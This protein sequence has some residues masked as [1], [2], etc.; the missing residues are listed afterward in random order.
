MRPVFGMT[1]GLALL[2]AGTAGAQSFSPPPSGSNN[3][4]TSPGLPQPYGLRWQSLGGG[5]SSLGLD[6]TARS[7]DLQFPQSTGVPSTIYGNRTSPI[8]RYTSRS[9]PLSPLQ[10][11]FGLPRSIQPPAASS[12]PLFG[13]NRLAEPYQPG[14]TPSSA[15]GLQAGR[16]RP[17]GPLPVYPVQPVAPLAPRDQGPTAYGGPHA[18]AA[19]GGAGML[20]LPRL[21]W[22][23]PEE[24]VPPPQTGGPGASNLIQQRPFETGTLPGPMRLGSPLDQIVQ[25]Q[26]YGAMGGTRLA[27]PEGSLR[28]PAPTPERPAAPTG[29]PPATPGQPS[30]AIRAGQQPL[31][32]PAGVE[33][34]TTRKYLDKATAELKAGDYPKAAGSYELARVVAPRS[35]APLLGRTVAL[36]ATGDLH[37]AANNLML[38]VD[39]E[40]G[41]EVFRQD[42]RSMLPDQELLKRRVAELQESLK[43]F[44]DFRLRFLLGYLEY[45]TGDETSG[46]LD[47]TQAVQKF[48]AER[49]AARKL[50]ETLRKSRLLRQPPTTAPAPAP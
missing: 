23:R 42:I 32:T 18:G 40:P 16:A 15:G 33:D 35:P 45:C 6:T 5:Y 25:E 28:S 7:L 2:V 14:Q 21:P 36:V 46:L 4:Y 9:A 38:A 47:M 26:P 43:L 48:P 30:A 31:L 44:D 34:G 20:A 37:T 41:P 1:L 27:A 29:P 11:T 24:N 17:T 13:R 3:T 12:T 22:E 39:L 8:E 10:Q 49:P 19:P 50:V